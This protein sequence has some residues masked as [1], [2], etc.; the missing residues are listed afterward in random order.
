MI[1]SDDGVH[2]LAADLFRGRFE[3]QQPGSGFDMVYRLPA[4]E[5]HVIEI[6]SQS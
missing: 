1:A 5:E 3:G 2:S 6:V 4:K